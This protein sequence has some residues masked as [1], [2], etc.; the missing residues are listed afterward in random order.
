MG[1][2]ANQAAMPLDA[3]QAQLMAPMDLFD[4]IW[5]R[6]CNQRIYQTH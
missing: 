2:D 1:L 4:S 3:A 6:E 5:G